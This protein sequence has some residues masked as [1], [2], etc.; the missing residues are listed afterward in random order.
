MVVRMIPRES[1][2]RVEVQADALYSIYNGWGADQR[3]IQVFNSQAGIQ[4][5]LL[6]KSSLHPN[7]ILRRNIINSI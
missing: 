3:W 5:I 4:G 7:F 6:L 2:L 1:H